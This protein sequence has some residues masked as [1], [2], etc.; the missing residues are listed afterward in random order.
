MNMSFR[1]DAAFYALDSSIRRGNKVAF[2]L[3]ATPKRESINNVSNSSKAS[4]MSIYNNISNAMDLVSGPPDAKTRKYDR[5]LRF[6]ASSPHR[7][8]PCN[9]PTN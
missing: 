5:Q 4:K 9:L 8:K 7:R 6:V 1:S 2:C 3:L